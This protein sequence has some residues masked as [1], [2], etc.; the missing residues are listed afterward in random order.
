MQYVHVWI[1]W[2]WDGANPVLQIQVDPKNKRNDSGEL[3][4]WFCFIGNESVKR[5]ERVDLVWF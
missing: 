1:V 5:K 2:M 3:I 4:H